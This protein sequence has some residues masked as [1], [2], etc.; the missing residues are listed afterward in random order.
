M[1]TKGLKY[2][3]PLRYPGGKA[4]LADLLAELRRLNHLGE[5]PIA[6]PFAG[7]AGASLSLLY[8]EETP[9]VHINDADPAIHAFWKA[10]MVRPNQFMAKLD[11]TLVDLAEWKRQ[12]EVHRRP[13]RA[14]VTNL[15]FAT[16]YLNRCNRSG[17][18]LKGGPIGGLK[19][20]GRWKIDA[21]YNRDEL[22]QRCKRVVEYRDRIHVT[23]D[24]GLEFIKKH[25]TEKLFF[26]IDPPYYEKGPTL[27]L[28]S[29][30]PSYHEALARQ[31]KGM[32]DASWVMTYDNAKEIRALYE[33]WAQ[34]HE[35]QLDYAASGRRKGH[36][37]F[38]CPRH[39]RIPTSQKSAAIQW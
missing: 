5:L 13:S 28:N 31:L 18:I 34:V 4:A 39:L 12:R 24:D 23:P 14:S 9:A 36:E 20:K 32:Q 22:R 19:Q 25:A 8:G 10:L 33:P 11:N 15:G 37:L 21:R 3:S 38:I 27:Y 1:R 26:F 35:F 6:E 2:A 16:F 30:K 17:I 7:G 29:L